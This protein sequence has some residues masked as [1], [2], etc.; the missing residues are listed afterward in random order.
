MV[1]YGRTACHLCADARALVRDVCEQARE[2]WREVD[3]D[4]ATGDDG[5]PLAD[6]L[7]ELVP[8]VEVDGVRQGYWRLDADRLLRALARR[9]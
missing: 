1:L 7:G 4:E 9:P 6:S 5:R 2:T 8:V 3:V